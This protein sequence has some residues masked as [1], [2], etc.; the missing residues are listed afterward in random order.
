MASGRF[1]KGAVNRR[2]WAAFD[3]WVLDGPQPVLG[4]SDECE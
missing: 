2:G 1:D 3:S 4:V